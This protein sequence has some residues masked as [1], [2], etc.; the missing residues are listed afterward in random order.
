MNIAIKDTSLEEVV[1]RVEAGEQ[2][3]LTRDGRPVAKVEPPGAVAAFASKPRVGAFEE[4]DFWISE[5]FD[6]LEP[7]WDEYVS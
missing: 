1:R 4:M 7:E 2:V 3:T 5:D 6:I